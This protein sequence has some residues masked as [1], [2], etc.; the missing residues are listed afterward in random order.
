[1]KKHPILVVFLILF[2]LFVLVF[3]LVV[4]VGLT[5]GGGFFRHEPVA[6]ITIEGPIFDSTDTLKDLNELAEDQSVKAIVI[7]LDSPGGAVGPAQE[8]YRELIKLRKS[9]KIVASMGSVA[10]SGA[11]YIASAAHHIMANAG[12]VTGSIG[13]IMESFGVQNMVDKVALEHRVV[14]S[15]TYKDVGTPF[16]AMTDPDR[17]YLQQL[18]DS[19]YGQF[20]K[21]VAVARNIPLDKVMLMAEGRVYTGE[22]AKENGLIDELGNFYD[23]ISVAKKL[24]GL[25][26]DAKVRWP[27]EPSPFEKFM[28]GQASS[29]VL[30]IFLDKMGLSRLPL[31]YYN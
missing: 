25:A 27:R 21:D 10:A 1:M 24:A 14:K 29:S 31:M 30:S 16:R 5:G 15:G 2:G 7:R 4:C 26:D 9:K 20:T 23:A 11:Y 12:T 19:M 17:A 3:G 18:I 8:I 6:V 28:G 13:V 22:Q